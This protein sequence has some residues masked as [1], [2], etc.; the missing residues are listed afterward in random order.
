MDIGE[1]DPY[2]YDVTITPEVISKSRSCE[3]LKLLSD[4]YKPSH[5]GNM[6]LAYDGK[7]SAFPAGHVPF[8]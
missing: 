7:K 6:M 2:Q 1:K 3:I 5:M 8:K 4:L